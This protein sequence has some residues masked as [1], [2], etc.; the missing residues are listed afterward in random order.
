MLLSCGGEDT[1][2]NEKG[3]GNPEI[4][5]AMVNGKGIRQASKQQ[6]GLGTQQ[7]VLFWRVGLMWVESACNTVLHSQFFFGQVN[8]L[9]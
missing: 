3:V 2:G 7:G 5:T 4:L 6:N 8:C 1:Q 9:L